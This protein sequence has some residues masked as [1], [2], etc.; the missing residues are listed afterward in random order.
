MMSHR[1]KWATLAALVVVGWGCEPAQK[2]PPPAAQSVEPPPVALSPLER[3]ERDVAA[4]N[5]QTVLWRAQLTAFDR[6]M[7]AAHNQLTQQRRELLSEREPPADAKV[8]SVLFSA[9]NHGEREDCGC[10]ANPLGGLDRRATLIDYA[11][12][13]DPAGQTYWGRLGPKTEAL[14]VVDAGESLFREM[15]FRVDREG[16][17]KATFELAQAVVEGMNA[18]AP[19]VLNVGERELALGWPALERL[20][21]IAKFPF[22]SANLRSEQGEPLLRP[23]VVV[24]RGG[25]KVAF[26]GMVRGHSWVPDF[27]TA[28]KIKLEDPIVAYKAALATLPADLDAVILLSD[29]G[30]EGSAKLVET[31]KA[32]SLRVDAVIVAGSNQMTERP[33]WSK[34]TPIVEPMSRGKYFGRLDLYAKDPQGWRFGNDAPDALLVL[35]RYRQAWSSYM[36]GRVAMMQDQEQLS[37]LELDELK[38]Q[39]TPS[40]PPAKPQAKP[41]PTTI[42]RLNQRLDQQ[43]KRQQLYLKSWSDESVALEA[44][45]APAQSAGE[46][47]VDVRVV[48]VKLAIPQD[49]AA[50][51]ALDRYKDKTWDDQKLY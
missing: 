3:K 51:K 28:R 31:L 30:V 37:Q 32:Q 26:I 9:N 13:D 49:K 2:T 11:R 50:R 35:D 38:Q 23:A 41:D 47:W 4:L 6:G 43:K 15:N 7:A 12:K 33:R 22:I 20:S 1:V 25:A 10:K 45:L 14:F 48:E 8:I 27:L 29:E 40:T 24:E 39:S 46:D 16:V 5:A 17:P 19:D 36:H 21:K 18:A 34:G 44:A 42:T